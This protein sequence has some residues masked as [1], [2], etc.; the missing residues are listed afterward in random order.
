MLEKLRR[1]LQS[2]VGWFVELP[3]RYQMAVA[4]VVVPAG[5][6][7]LAVGSWSVTVALPALAII[8]L[9]ALST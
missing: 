9:W 2:L 3:L 1:M 6:I 4:A 8:G 7:G 5:S